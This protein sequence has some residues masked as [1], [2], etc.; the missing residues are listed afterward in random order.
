MTVLH[1]VIPRDPIVSPWRMHILLW[2]L[3]D[4]GNGRSTIWLNWPDF[5]GYVTTP[6]HVRRRKMGFSCV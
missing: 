4:K 5:L 3:S 2:C 6:S 1:D